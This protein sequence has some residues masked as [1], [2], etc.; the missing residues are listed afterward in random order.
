MLVN[1]FFPLSCEDGPCWVVPLI[2]YKGWLHLTH[3]NHPVVNRNRLQQPNKLRVSVEYDTWSCR[4]DIAVQDILVCGHFKGVESETSRFGGEKY[5][6]VNSMAKK[7][8]Q[9]MKWWTKEV[10]RKLDMNN[11]I[12]LYSFR[13]TKKRKRQLTFY[14]RFMNEKT[15]RSWQKECIDCVSIC[16]R[17]FNRSSPEGMG[18]R[19]GK[20]FTAIDCRS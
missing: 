7:I 8:W 12:Q 15:G 3:R 14:G 6:D 19:T 17:S 20:N 13:A 16:F 9:G 18:K 10:F 11:I 1:S 2:N 5:F 4:L